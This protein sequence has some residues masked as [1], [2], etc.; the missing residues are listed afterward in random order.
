[1]VRS[2]LARLSIITVVAL[3][4]CGQAA[5]PSGHTGRGD[6]ASVDT[7]LD[8][9][10]V[11]ITV[12]GDQE[13]VRLLGINAPERDECW[14]DEARAAL[15]ALVE[16]SAVTLHEEGR[17]QFGRL[18]AYLA[19]DGVDVNPRLV[20]DGHALATSDRHQQRSAFLGAERAA[21]ENGAGLWAVDACGPPLPAHGVSIGHVEYDAPGDDAQNPNGEWVTI[22]NDGD[23]ADLSGWR[24]R[25][26]SSVH[27]YRFPDGF[28]L[29][30]GEQVRVRSGCGDDTATDLYW[31][32]DGAVWNNSGDIALLQDPSG[33]VVSWHRYGD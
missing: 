8:G 26:E 12:D 15:T 33:N 9:D 17:D 22:A 1:M 21:Q 2:T 14:G 11:R 32:A 29:D 4:A 31:C 27:R 24:L 28:T 13:E 18:L 19:A 20:G 30:E 25:D 3:A 6:A 23:G 5:D 16:G 10:S 7:V